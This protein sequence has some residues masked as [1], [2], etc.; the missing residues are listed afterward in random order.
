MTD[1]AA[2]AHEGARDRGRLYAVLAALYLAQGVPGYLLLVALPPIMREGGASRTAIGLF[3][4]LMLPLVLKFAVAPLVDRWT[5]LPRLGHRRG[6]IVPTQA[7]VALGIASMALFEPS[8]VGPLFAIAL[9]ITILSSLQDIATDGFAVRRLDEASR[10]V[11]NAIQGAAIAGGVVMGGTL[12]LVLNHA[13]GWRPTLLVVAALALLPLIALPWMTERDRSAPKAPAERPSLRRFFRIDGAWLILAFALTYRAS[14]GLVRG[15]EGP[16]LVDIGLPTDWIGYLSGGAATTAGLLG[17]AAAALLLRKTGIVATLL[18][19]GGLRSLCFLAYALNAMEIWPGFSVAITAS[20]T[21]TCIRYMELVA[22]YTLFM[23]VASKDQPGT[24]FT[25]LVCAELV[26]YLLGSTIAGALA[27]RFGYGPLFAAAAA[28]SAIGV[29][30]SAVILTFWLKRI[31][32]RG[33][34]IASPA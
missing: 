5:P 28:F 7:L 12:A 24:D 31:R 29:G 9:S 19:L 27:D 14:E 22:I 23:R 18:L 15:M 30:V 1:A 8:D 4:L 34:G 16:Y 3:Y 32:S 25:L 17:A 10:P 33:A 26:I 11:G 2:P 21:Q 13:I 20:A 6:W